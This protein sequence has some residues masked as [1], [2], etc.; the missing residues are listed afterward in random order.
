MTA[1]EGRKINLQIV[2]KLRNLTFITFAAT[3]AALALQGSA[4]AASASLSL[5]PASGSYT[6][7]NKFTVTINE[8]STDVINAAEP[9]LTYNTSQLQFDSLTNTGAFDIP[10]PTTSGNGVVK[11]PVAKSGSGLTGTQ[12]IGTVT[13]KVLAAGSSTIS[14]AGTSAIVTGPTPPPTNIWDKISTAGTFTLVAA[15]TTT[16]PPPPPPPTTPATVKKTSNGTAT[17]PVPATTTPTTSTPTTTSAPTPIVQGYYVAIKVTDTGGKVVANA[18]VN[19]DDET[20]QTNS[21]GI[22]S[23]TGISSG[24]HTVTT[25]IDGKKVSQSIDVAE[26]ATHLDVQQFGVHVAGTKSTNLFWIIALVLAVIAIG[27]GGLTFGQIFTKRHRA[28]AGGVSTN[29][30]SVNPVAVAPPVAATSSQ[31]DTNPTGQIF[32]PATGDSTPPDQGD[33]TNGN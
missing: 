8:T 24:T 12:T 18:A 9:D 30:S 2:R 16:P 26:A 13:F 20:S 32:Y 15:T 14:F 27:G 29:D 17:T 5:S 4:S 7:G 33:T 11:I 19:L 22:A 25:V 23:F 1:N 28:T 21:E 31:T 6:V 3:L 10:G